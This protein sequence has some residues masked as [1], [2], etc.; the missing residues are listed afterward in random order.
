MKKILG[1]FI[2]LLT[3]GAIF[4]VVCL[5]A[6]VHD[7]SDK[8][9]VRPYFFRIS[10]SIGAPLSFSQVGERKVRDW[11]V[12]KYVTDYFYII[13]NSVNMADRIKGD[14]NFVAMRSSEAVFKNW[15]KNVAP[16]MQELAEQGARRTVRVFDEILTSESNNYLRVDYE[17]K[18]WYKPNDLSEVPT[19]ERGTLYLELAESS[20]F[21]VFPYPDA[22]RNWLI[23][24]GDPA[25]VF[26]F[27]VNN[28][29]MD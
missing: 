13:P 10:Q 2:G 9:M 11:L 21:Q 14:G 29:I 19:T 22:V 25:A 24:R 17:L 6:I 27:W 28:V 20:D 7:T 1:F 4:A 5:T 23:H 18:T 16:R 26:K 15:V 12:Q 8:V 3:M